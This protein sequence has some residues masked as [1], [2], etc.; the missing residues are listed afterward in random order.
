MNIRKWEDVTNVVL[1]FALA[2]VIFSLTFLLL[3]VGFK[4]LGVWQ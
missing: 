1:G 4:L 2:S 3:A